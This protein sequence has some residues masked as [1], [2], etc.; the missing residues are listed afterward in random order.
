M[1]LLRSMFSSVYFDPCRA[2]SWNNWQIRPTVLI[3][4]HIKTLIIDWLKMYPFLSDLDIHREINQLNYRNQWKYNKCTTI[5]LKIS[6]SQ[7]VRSL[8]ALIS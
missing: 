3:E 4:F 6:F 5:L 7:S 8:S 2:H 1:R